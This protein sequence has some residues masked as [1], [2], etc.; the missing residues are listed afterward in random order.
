[1][2]IKQVT[3]KANRTTIVYLKR[4]TN[5]NF[6][7]YSL[8]CE[9]APAPSFDKKLQALAPDLLEICELPG[10]CGKGLR[11]QGVKFSYSGENDVMGA[12]ITGI[13][14]LQKSNG[15]LVLNTP[16]KPSA[17]PQGRHEGANVLAFPCVQRLEAL[18]V[19]AK[20]YLRGERAQG[21]LLTD[22]D[23]GGPEPAPGAD[24]PFGGDRDEL[25]AL[26]P[27]AIDVMRETHRCSI[28]S[29]Q[30]RLKI[31]FRKATKLVE[32]LEERG[33]VSGPTKNGG[34]REILVDLTNKK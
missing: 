20:Q 28:S 27:K 33:L 4:N 30:R 13:R 12:T 24:E 8:S 16:H 11:I 25:D 5:D 7:E 32:R 15:V 19:E 10:S 31:G 21:E 22:P 18:I 1:M 9:D 3:R 34:P 29:F 23:D 17:T 6:D 26:I 2:K 14:K